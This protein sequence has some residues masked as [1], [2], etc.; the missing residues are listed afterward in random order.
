MLAYSRVATRGMWRL[1][2]KHVALALN[3]VRDAYPPSGNR[4]R[5]RGSHAWEHEQLF[6]V[7]SRRILQLA[8]VAVCMY[9]CMY[10]CQMYVCMCFLCMFVYRKYLGVSCVYS[11]CVSMWGGKVQVAPLSL[12]LSL[13]L[14]LPL[15]PLYVVE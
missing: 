1:S 14:S 4:A 3:A 15:S 7:A 2:A 9:V 6:L 8:T 13:S 5:D 10:L 11:V 12:S